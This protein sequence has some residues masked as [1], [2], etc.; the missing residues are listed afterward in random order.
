M[1]GFDVRGTAK[2][3]STSNDDQAHFRQKLTRFK[4]VATFFPPILEDS[5][6]AVLRRL[7]ACGHQNQALTIEFITCA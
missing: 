4:Y 3:P 6:S 7:C 2:V 1:T 5:N